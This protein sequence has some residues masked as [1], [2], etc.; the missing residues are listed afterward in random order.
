MPQTLSPQGTVPA[1]AGKA[2]ENLRTLAMILVSVAIA[3]LV[4]LYFIL[5]AGV[6]PAEAY[7][8]LLIRPFTSLSSLGEI[9]IKLV[10][11]LLIGIGVSFTFSAKLTNLGG[12]GQMLMG[13]LGMTLAGIPPIGPALGVFS[14]PVGFLLGILLGGAWAAIA[15][16][17]KVFF[18][19]SEIITT[20]ML[21]YIA[22]QFISY[23]IYHPMKAPGGAP[24]SEKIAVTL[25]RLF[26]GSRINAGL[27]LALLAVAAYWVVIRRTRYGYNLRV[28]GGSPRAAGYSGINT[29]RVQ[30]SALVVSG[31]FAG[32]A[33]AIEVAGTQTRLVEGLAGSYGFDGV[34][35]S[36]L[37]MLSPIGVLVASVFYAGLSVGAEGMQVRTGI[38]SSF[39]NILSALIVLFILLGLSYS[40]TGKSPFA[41]LFAKKEA[42]HG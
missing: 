2:K 41:R 13:A 15:G 3:L 29:K 12:G 37:G 25:P 32:L 1:R 17:F 31:A 35:V 28:L 5:S 33:G 34:V 42:R 23:L 6:N 26:T 40:R 22:I 14:I 27:V 9:S 21:N 20:L 7:Y 24:Q 16:A 18:G 8:I 4:G 19:S 30:F 38:P 11:I 39:L 36:L 10:P